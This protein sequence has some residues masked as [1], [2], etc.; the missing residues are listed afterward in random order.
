MKTILSCLCRHPFGAM[1]GL[2]HYQRARIVAVVN[3]AVRLGNDE[4]VLVG[5]KDH[6]KWAM[7]LCPCGC[8]ETIHVDLMTS[9]SPHW[10]M[11]RH[12]D[13]SISFRPSVWL[14]N[15]RCGSHFILSRG[16]VVWCR[17]EEDGER[18]SFRR[19]EER[20]FDDQG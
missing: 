14:D 3:D 4:I 2:R 10:R 6:P 15:G 5:P 7:L 19:R 13:G 12:R 16:R 18:G 20:A 11:I 8:G 9:H 17:F 1:H